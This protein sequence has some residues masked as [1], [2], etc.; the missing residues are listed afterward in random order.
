MTDQSSKK[1]PI[2]GLKSEFYCRKNDVNYYMNRQNGIIFLNPMPNTNHMMDYANDHYKTGVYKDYVDAK[3][4]KILTANIRLNQIDHYSPGHTML[5]IGCSTGFFIE[6]AKARGYDVRG[7][8]FA[9]AAIEHASSSVRDKIVQG[10]VHQVLGQWQPHVDWISAFDII[11]HMHDPV[12]FI[13]D[14]KSILKPGGFLVMSS[15][16][17]GHFLRRLMGASWPMLQPFQHTVLFSRRAMTEM[18]EAAQF[19]N[20]KIQTT[21]KYVTFAYLARQLSA[22]NKIIS[23]LMG[24]VVAITPKSLVNR[25]FRVNIGEFIVFAHTSKY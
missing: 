8:E 7:I 12:K 15:P 10:D 3:E 4:L 2:T 19:T 13:T 17:S 20:I 24:L 16:D 5:D 9:A 23:F 22:T 14:I 11:E 25:P 18:L 21:H 1:C 6:A